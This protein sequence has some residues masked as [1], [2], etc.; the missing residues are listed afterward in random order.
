[1]FVKRNSIFVER[2]FEKKIDRFFSLFHSQTQ[3][4]RLATEGHCIKKSVS[5]N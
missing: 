4:L 3:Q 1:M 5:L 2:E